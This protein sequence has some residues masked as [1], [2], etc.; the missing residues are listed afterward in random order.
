MENGKKMISM[1]LKTVLIIVGVSVSFF[2]A[3]LGMANSFFGRTNDLNYR[4][5]AW[6]LASTVTAMLDTQKIVRLKADVEAV[7]DTVPESERVP[8]SEMGTAAFDAY[9]EHFSKIL[10]TTEYRDTEDVLR[11]IQ[12]ENIAESIYIWYTV[13]DEKQIV[14]LAYASETEILPGVFDPLYEQNWY[15]LNQPEVGR[16]PYI[17]N[18]DMYGWL[19]TAVVPI[20]DEAGE[21]VAYVG[22]DIRMNEIKER[23]RNFCIRL[24]LVL[25]ALTVVTILV[26]LLLIN[27]LLIRPINELTDAANRYV[28]KKLGDGRHVFSEVRISANNEIGKLAATMS[29]MEEDIDEYID[30]LTDM[31]AHRQHY[32]TELEVARN[33]LK[34]ILPDCEDPFP[35]HKEIDLYAM[36]KPQ[37]T[38]GADAYDFALLDEDHLMV[39]ITDVSE[40]GIPAALYMM[41]TQTMLR[42]RARR[43][44]TP[45]D[46][47]RDINI[48]LCESN[49]GDVF[50]TAWLGIIDL[51]SG[52]VISANAGHEYPII[53]HAGEEYE[54]LRSSHCPPLGA[55]DQSEF[56]NESFCLK[57]GDTLFLYTDGVSEAKNGDGK[58]FTMMRLIDVL[59]KAGDAEAKKLVETVEHAVSEFSGTADPYDDITMMALR[60]FGKK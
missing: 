11:R 1:R 31:T 43:G 32:R 58:R 7:W 41:R 49:A 18:T 55:S 39:S 23:E 20:R 44:G 26:Y 53:R 21:T 24:A 45:A 60:Y 29:R 3:A 40:Q 28:E 6:D 50:V 33:I 57:P 17:T 22:V 19:C 34:D 48:L 12:A 35:E 2:A 52:E 51:K 54:P 25:G 13:G 30:E 38:I 15:I 10:E 9:T 47:F 14:Y 46:M 5:F 27:R 59:N 4:D 36:M 8:S 42:G 37:T 16:E 56:V